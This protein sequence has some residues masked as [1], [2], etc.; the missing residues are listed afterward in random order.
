MPVLSRRRTLNVLQPGVLCH[1]NRFE[2]EGVLPRRDQDQR[3]RG[4]V[5]PVME[6]L[7]LQPGTQPGIEDIRLV[8]PKRRLQPALNLE[9][10]E[11]KF[12]DGNIPGKIK[13]YFPRPS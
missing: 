2:L 8:L 11:L 7:R 12:D 6:I 10:I 1:T 5:R 3:D 9:M 4:P 13:A